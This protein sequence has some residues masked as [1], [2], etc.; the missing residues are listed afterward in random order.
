MGRL[1]S[2]V[3]SGDLAKSVLARIYQTVMHADE[4]LQQ[5]LGNLCKAGAHRQP[6]RDMLKGFCELLAK[7]GV[8]AVELEGVARSLEAHVG[9][10][11]QVDIAEFLSAWRCA[12]GVTADRDL[13]PSQVDLATRISRLLGLENQQERAGTR[14][15][16]LSS[17]SAAS[18]S[19]LMEFFTAA[20][21]NGDGYLSLAE[22]Q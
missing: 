5:L 11:E 8:S 2:K 4:S 14:Q 6:T 20:D 12:S 21:A 17:V 22:G 15:R 3:V 9:G 10:K 1:E 19:K 16:R 18:G 13:T 7:N